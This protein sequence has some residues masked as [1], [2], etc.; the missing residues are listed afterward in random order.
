MSKQ[1]LAAGTRKRH[2]A[3]RQVISVA[4]EGWT[5]SK[6]ANRGL[7]VMCGLICGLV[8]ATSVRAQDAA[9]QKPSEKSATK[10]DS[11][12][13]AVKFGKLRDGKGKVGVGAIV[14]G[15]GGG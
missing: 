10:S 3:V 6:R 7:M 15:G 4:A 5:M 8:F 13:K 12:V 2:N 1:R 11:K 9:V 14:V